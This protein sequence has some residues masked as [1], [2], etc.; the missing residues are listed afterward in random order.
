[1]FVS[2]RYAIYPRFFSNFIIFTEENA[3]NFPVLYIFT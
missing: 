2:F 1:M 3:V